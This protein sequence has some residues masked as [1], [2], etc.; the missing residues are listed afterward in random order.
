MS[1]DTKITL[2]IIAAISFFMFLMFAG[3]T[4][5]DYTEAQVVIAK[6]QS[7]WMSVR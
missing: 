1:D 2:S 6:E 5:S 4:L 3:I 7:K